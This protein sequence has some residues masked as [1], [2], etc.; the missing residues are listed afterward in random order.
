MHHPAANPDP[1]PPH[2]SCSAQS[3]G[4]PASRSPRHDSSRPS[5][6]EAAADAQSTDPAATPHTT[7]TDADANRPDPNKDQPC[8]LNPI[9]P[10]CRQPHRQTVPNPVRLHQP[11]PSG[12]RHALRSPPSPAPERLGQVGVDAAP[13]PGQRA[14]NRSTPQPDPL[15]CR[16]PCRDLSVDQ[17]PSCKGRYKRCARACREE[18]RPSMDGHPLRRD[19]GPLTPRR[20][21]LVRTRTAPVTRVGD[22]P[23]AKLADPGGGMGAGGRGAA[24]VAGQGNGAGGAR[25]PPLKGSASRGD[26]S[27]GARSNFSTA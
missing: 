20:G 25:L 5:V 10:A 23:A 21:L 26:H 18:T 17:P 9:Q 24:G 1:R 11:M 13:R 4:L 16:K 6:P 8:W 12:E 2:E 15:R 3:T 22:E 14:A 7:T 19:S 27:T